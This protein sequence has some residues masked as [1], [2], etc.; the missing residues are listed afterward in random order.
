M[1][2]VLGFSWEGN[3][4]KSTLINGS[5]RLWLL[6]L[7]QIL[8]SKW[9]SVLVKWEV[10]RVLLESGKYQL[11]RD[12]KEFQEKIS[13]DEYVRAHHLLKERQQ[14]DVI[15]CDRTFMDNIAYAMFNVMQWNIDWT[16]RLQIPPLAVQP[17][18]RVYYFDTPI[19]QN[20]AFKDY[21]NDRIGKEI[22]KLNKER[23]GKIVKL[24]QNCMIDREK[25]ISD[26]L[27]FMKN[28]D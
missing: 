22:W 8:E 4:W 15:L 1:W 19:K 12:M 23:F 25:V 11:P 7:K 18:D 9:Y 2:K 5:E 14:Y 17:Y 28:N 21:N 3:L 20:T 10:A 6:W 16:I 24:Y 27:S 26:V 13:N